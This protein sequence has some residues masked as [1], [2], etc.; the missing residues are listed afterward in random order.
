MS[1]QV[2]RTA[3]VTGS[4]QGI[5]A[6]IVASLQNHG[7]RVIGVDKQPDSQADVSVQVDLSDW[8]AIEGL[9][10]YLVDIDILVNNAAVL[11]EKSV[12]EFTESQFALIHDVNLRAPFLLCR[13]AG[14]AM[15]ARGFGRIIN[16]SSVGARTG[17]L[18]DSAVYSASKAGLVSMTKHFARI[19]GPGGVTCNAVLP[20]AIETPMAA[21]QFARDPDLRESILQRIPLGRYGS[22]DDVAEAVSFLAS[23][24]AGFITGV[25]LDVNGGWIMV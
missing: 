4:A 20:G 9:R 19:L 10:K 17:G 3:M 23:D 11:V 18:S 12:S 25:S 5:G 8:L 14:P 15:G 22:G 24:A 7:I 16:V 6:A 1:K 21:A 2:S 13:T